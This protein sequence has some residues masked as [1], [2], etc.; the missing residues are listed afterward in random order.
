M[1]PHRG[2]TTG[3]VTAT[4]PGVADVL[5]GFCQQPPPAEGYTLAGFDARLAEMAEQGDALAAVEDYRGVFHL[6]YLTFSR[7][8]RSALALNR[9]ADEAW[10]VDMSCRFVDAYIEQVR[11]W[12]RGDPSQCQAWRAAFGWAQTGRANVLQAMFLGMNAHIH[13][14]LAFVTLGACRAAGDLDEAADSPTRAGVPESRYRDFLLINQIGW[15]SIP[16]I[17]D[18]VLGTFQRT[19]QWGNRPVAN[20]TKALGQRLLMHARD[21]S[22]CHTALLVHAQ[23]ERERMAVAA[24]IDAHAASYI[25]LVEALTLRPR[26]L[27]RALRRWREREVDLPAHAR[28]QLL[29][30]ATTNPVVAELALHQLAFA[31]ADPSEVVDALVAA[32]SPRLVSAFAAMVARHAP[33]RRRSE[34]EAHWSRPGPRS[35][36][37]LEAVLLG[38]HVPVADLP[39]GPVATVCRG[40]Q[41]DLL[42]TR[43]CASVPEVAAIPALRWALLHH[44]HKLSEQ[45]TRAGHADDVPPSGEQALPIAQARALL[46]THPD[47]WVRL[48]ATRLTAPPPREGEHDVDQL[49]E[50]VLYLKDT[51]MFREVDPTALLPVAEE[52]E[53]RS[54]VEGEVILRSGDPPTGVHLITD[55]LVRVT[56]ARAGE[57]VLVADLRRGDA[58]GELSALNETTAT[59]DCTAV[60]AVHTLFLPTRV[61]VAL[62]HQHPLIGLGLVRVLS[63]RL[64][65]TTLLVDRGG[66]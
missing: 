35:T 36:A 4:P 22:W 15:E 13:Y 40:W 50:T 26:R 25:H 32:G 48:C 17:Q 5:I 47:A 33:A 16:H 46:A 63:Q 3:A 43:L 7:Q 24:M 64:M 30:M 21:T 14:D 66:T 8:V 53:A 19:L 54:F 6:T 49:I 1:E 61:L 27:A 51:S 2:P 55:G 28:D 23:D 60:T 38:G 56:Q 20:V 62:L 58:L 34:L 37:A 52:L 42:D 59:A 10:A 9:F 12:E 44:A 41:R 65:T 18:T 57:H 31:G 45:L 29:T 39:A 11:R